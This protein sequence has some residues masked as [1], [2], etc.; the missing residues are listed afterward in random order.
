MGHIGIQCAFN[1]FIKYLLKTYY[2]QGIL[3]GVRD[4]HTDDACT[5]GAYIQVG[6]DDNK[7]FRE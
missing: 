2:R 6:E 3:V 5:N 4:T 1:K 7:H